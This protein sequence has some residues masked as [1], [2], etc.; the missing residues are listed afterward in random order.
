ME[1]SEKERPY[2]VQLFGSE[3]KHFAMA[4]KLVTK[5]IQPDGID[6]NFGCPA[7]KIVKNS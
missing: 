6:I 5:K 2:V 1:F 4:T 3:P 7:K